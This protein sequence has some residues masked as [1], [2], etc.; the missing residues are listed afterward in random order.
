L[1][2]NEAAWLMKK[3]AP[4][5][6]KDAPYTEPAADEI[7]V[8]NRAIAVNPV[9]WALQ[10]MGGM[11][12]NWIKYPF[13]LG[14]DVA[15]EVV[16]VGSGVAHV[17]LG[18]RVLAMAAGG[19]KQRNRAAEGAFQAYSIVLERM[20]TVIPES[21][22]FVEAAVV[23]LGLTTAAY[24]LF[25]SDLL[26]LELPSAAARL[27]DQW[28]IITG[29]ATSVGSN[30]IQ[31]AVAAG[32]GVVTTCSPKNYEYVTALGAS[33][34]VD[35]NGKDVVRE[36]VAALRGKAVV[37]ALAIGA[38]SVA[39]CID[40]LAQCEGRKFV[41]SCSAPVPLESLAQGRRVSLP[42]LLKALPVMLSGNARNNRASRRHQIPWKFFDASSLVDN[43]VGRYI[44]QDYLGPALA[45]GQFRPAPPPKVMGHALRD[46]Q[47]ALDTQRKGVSATKIVVAL[48]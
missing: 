43:P 15:G 45:S 32:Y 23:P 40:A 24:G 6:V 19:C 14:S 39:D 16:A 35:Y 7:V 36:L 17:K 26:A 47:A 28:V 8:R 44:Y 11:L 31:L 37:G 34:A 12:F 48:E 18:D 38:G 9:D 21:L 33:H 30:A 22:S 5:Q 10:Y 27:R 20:T 41:A 25:Q 1:P 29:G 2:N 4:L 3:H 46:L 42:V 13:I